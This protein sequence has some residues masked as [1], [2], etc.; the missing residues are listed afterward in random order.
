[1]AMQMERAMADDEEDDFITLRKATSADYHAI[2]EVATLSRLQSFK[3]YMTEE[4]VHDEVDIYYR[5][6]VLNEIINNP[7]NAI[8]LAER[9]TH[10][11][12]YLSVLPKDRRGHPRLLQFYV[13]PDVQRQG[14]GELLYEKALN[15]LHEAGINEMYISTM[16]ENVIGRRFYE[17]KGAKLIQEYDSIWDGKVHTIVVYLVKLLAH[18]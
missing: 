15:F 12:G 17:K 5:D 6:A 10:L 8:F 18:K 1:M 4:E 3:H 14:V 2:R 9:G 7:A 13:R 16:E 11:L